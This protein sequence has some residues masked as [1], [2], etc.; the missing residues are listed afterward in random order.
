MIIKD[1]LTVSQIAEKPE[2]GCYIHGMFLEGAR[3]DS[4][5]HILNHSKPKELFTDF[6]LVHLSPV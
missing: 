6:P 5:K 2:D 1:E 4:Q 3:W